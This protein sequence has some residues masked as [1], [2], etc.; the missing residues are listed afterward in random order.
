M[1][2]IQLYVR[3][4]ERFGTSPY[5]YP[6]Y[7]LGGLPEG[8]SRLCAIH[9]GTF[10]LQCP[11]EEVWCGLRFPHLCWLFEV[12][13]THVL[14]FFGSIF[15]LTHP[16]GGRGG[17]LGVHQHPPFI[18]LGTNFDAQSLVWEFVLTRCFSMTR[19]WRGES[20]PP[21]MVCLRSVSKNA[22]RIRKIHPAQRGGVC[23]AVR[24]V[25]F[26]YARFVCTSGCSRNN[27]L[28]YTE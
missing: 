15:D 13:I 25:F 2:S 4:L 1:K 27:R 6:M 28:I 12:G 16:E 24:R 7:G 11:V 8:F 3:S 18:S 22:S 14:L 17:A 9:G 5:I 10:M 19:A 26:Y 21:S 23:V 20:R